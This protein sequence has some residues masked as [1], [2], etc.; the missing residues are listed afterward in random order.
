MDV[1]VHS[2]DVGQRCLFFLTDV[3]IPTVLGVSFL[4]EEIIVG[5][6]YFGIVAY[7]FKKTFEFL[8]LV[9]SYGGFGLVRVN[10]QIVDRRVMFVIERGYFGYQ[11][12]GSCLLLRV[13]IVAY[14]GKIIAES[15]VCVF[16]LP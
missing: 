11:L 15:E 10:Q 5:I 12:H 9:V 8:Y 3:D 4:G 6:S 13:V 7:Q 14:L 1:I 16:A 2:D